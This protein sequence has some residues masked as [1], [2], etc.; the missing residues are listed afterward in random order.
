MLSER[1]CAHG[2]SVS[3]FTT[4]TAVINDNA[5][6][7]E[8]LSRLRDNPSARSAVSSEVAAIWPRPISAPITAAVG[9]NV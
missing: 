1:F 6:A 3:P 5:I 2:A 7:T 9:K 8:A 4:I